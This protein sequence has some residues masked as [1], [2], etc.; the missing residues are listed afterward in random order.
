MRKLTLAMG[1]TLGLVACM[2]S[3]ATAQTIIDN[4]SQPVQPPGGTDYLTITGPLGSAGTFVQ[5]GVDA[6]G[7]TRVYYGQKTNADAASLQLGIT[8]TQEYRQIANP[9]VS[10]RSKLLYGYSA[11]NTASL[12]ADNYTAGHTLSNLNLN[13]SGGSGIRLNYALGGVGSTGSITVTV[14]SG[15]ESSQQVSSVTLPIVSSAGSLLVFP[16][17][18]F[19]AANPSINLAD[20]DQIVVSL[21]GTPAGVNASI[22]NIQVSAVPEPA[23]ILLLGV[24]AVGCTAGYYVRNRKARKRLAGC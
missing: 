6:I 2:G 18:A 3:P 4:F 20:V 13:A 16:N 5:T 8:S 1:L 7:G 21:N 11:V 9:V 24:T 23:S 22:D 14:I 15:S 17:L 19:Q 12:N 10:G